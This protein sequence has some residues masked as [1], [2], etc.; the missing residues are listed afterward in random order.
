MM[1][2]VLG[3]PMGVRRISRCGQHL[4]ELITLLNLQS[5]QRG[6]Y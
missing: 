2:L 1:P 6:L 5:F 3:F 4:K